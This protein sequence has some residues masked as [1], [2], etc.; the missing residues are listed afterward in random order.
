MATV[1]SF[2]V[3]VVREALRSQGLPGDSITNEGKFNP[4][5][6]V[7]GTYTQAEFWTRVTPPVHFDVVDLVKDG[8][9]HPL[10][11]FLQPTIVLTGPAGRLVIAPYGE[12]ERGLVNWVAPAVVGFLVVLGIGAL[13]K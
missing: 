6:F 12:A 4:T 11:E 9:P 8:P 13:R 10:T 3:P 1:P 2:L 7:E 5:A